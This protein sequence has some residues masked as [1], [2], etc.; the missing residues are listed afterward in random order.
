MA[1]TLTSGVVSGITITDADAAPRRVVRDTLRMVARRGRHDP[2][3]RLLRRQRGD[4]IQRAPLLE[5]ARHL[6]VFELQ[7]DFCPVMRESVSD[8]AHGRAVDRSVQAFAGGDNFAQRK[9]QGT[10]GSSLLSYAPTES[11]RKAY[12]AESLFIAVL[13]E[14]YT[15]CTFAAIS[16][17]EPA[18][19]RNA[20]RRCLPSG[21][22]FARNISGR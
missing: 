3:R 14:P 10:C 2:A 11:A 19:Q 18:P 7:K 1:C 22:R 5:A 17:W 16:Q 8:R 21:N 20:S 15:G 6:Q 9:R 4:A 12:T 13:I